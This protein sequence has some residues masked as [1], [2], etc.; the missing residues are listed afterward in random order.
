[1]SE[2]EHDLL[3]FL[4]TESRRP[5]TWLA[6]FNSESHPEASVETLNRVEPLIR[7]G[8]IPQVTCKPLI[9]QLNLRNPFLFSAMS[10]WN[11]VFNQ[12]AETQKQIYRDP[13]FRNAFRATLKKAAGSV[14]IMTR[15]HRF[16]IQQISN[17]ALKHLEGKTLAD[18]AQERG[19][20]AVDALLDLALEDDLNVN[21][22]LPL[23]NADESKIP[24]LICDPRTMIG[25]SDGGAH[26]DQLC[27]AGYCTYLIGTWARDKSAMTLEYAVKRL[28]SEPADFFN[29]RGRGRIAVGNPADLAIFDYS[30]IGSPQ[31]G[32]IRNDLPGGGRRLVVPATGVQHTVVNGTVVY[33]DGKYTGTTPG[34]VLRS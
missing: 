13:E 20:D 11:R 18:V 33:E 32:E 34:A 8:G 4:L 29:L 7:R 5:V 16:E 25:L 6:L 12:P 30:A 23:M 19:T 15:G 9:F 3:D 28:T 10:C 24:Q 26:V 2:S 27:D 22:V 14:N 17:P 31:R 1:M 21:F